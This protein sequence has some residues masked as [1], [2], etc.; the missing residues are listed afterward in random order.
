MAPHSSTLAWRI[1][2]MGEPGGLPSMGSHRVGHNWSDLAVAAAAAGL[3]SPGCS[4]EGMMLKL[5]LVLWPPH[6]KSW[7]TGKDSDAGRDWGQGENGMTEDE[8]AG[9]L[10]LLDGLEF[11]WTPG[12]G[13]GQAGLACCD[14]WGHRV[15]HDWMAEMNWTE[16][17]FLS[18]VIRNVE[19]PCLSISLSPAHIP[20]LFIHTQFASTNFY[21]LNVC[22]IPEFIYWILNPQCYVIWKWGLFKTFRLWEWSLS[23]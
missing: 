20:I 23:W 10:H 7:L 17:Y 2:G 14:S 8:M 15:R 12:F 13:D 5:K 16:H 9:W 21:D 3:Y 4:L 6:A 1:P 18:N 22:P 19:R 11:K